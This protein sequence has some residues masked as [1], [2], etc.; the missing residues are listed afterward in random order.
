MT[1]QRSQHGYHGT[2]IHRIW[3][4][5]KRRCQNKNQI[6]YPQYS[7]R[8]IT[9]CDNWQQFTSFLEWALS[10]GYTDGLTL[11]RLDSNGNYEPSN[12]RWASYQEQGKN[13]RNA[14]TVTAFGETKHLTEWLKDPRVLPTT[15]Q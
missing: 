13:R 6:A 4:A 5:M 10:H 3:S 7:G 12:C 9:V 1:T 2:R 14:I 15:A 8:G 11:D